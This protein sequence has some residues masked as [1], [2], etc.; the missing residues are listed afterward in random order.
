MHKSPCLLAA[1][2]AIA[3]AGPANALSFDFNFAPSA[4][5]EVR[6]GMDIAAAY[7]SSVLTDDVTVTLD[8][9]VD[10]DMTGGGALGATSNTL[11]AITWGDARALLQSDMTTALDAQA[12]SSL[13]QHPEFDATTL[14]NN[15]ATNKALGLTQYANGNPL[16]GGVDAQIEFTDDLVFD[17]DLED[18]VASDKFDFLGVALH[19]I[20]HALGFNPN[21]PKFYGTLNQFRYNSPGQLDFST[22][23]DGTYFSI[24]DGATALFGGEFGA[25]HWNPDVPGD[26]LGIM[27]P[28]AT[29]GAMDYVSALDLAAFDAMGWD[30]N[31][32]VLAD[33]GYRVETAEIYRRFS[34]SAAPEPSAWALMIA[35]F[36]LVGGVLRRRRGRRACP[37]PAASRVY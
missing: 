18:G 24:D 8:V 15:T 10:H 11:D 1:M 9:S 27:S 5:P 19:E 31:F 4:T 32:D 2:G 16:S 35:G 33:P 20:G 25:G 23:G 12:L 37:P 28:Y 36:W 14:Y 29:G 34:S 13:D 17:F 30:L 6:R 7:W 3:V 21:F 26:P 22:L